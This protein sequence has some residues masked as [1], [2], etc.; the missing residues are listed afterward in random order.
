M[1]NTN[2]GAAAG[3]DVALST[4]HIDHKWREDFVLEQRLADRTGA[5]IG[6]ALATVDTHCAE[7]GESAAEAFGDPAAYSR[8]LVGDRAGEPVRIS[9]RTIGGIGCGL[10]G[11]LVVPRAFAAWVEG[12]TFSASAGDLVAWVIVAALAAI[13][14]V[15]PTPVLAWLVRRR[16]TAFATPFVVLILLLIPQLLLRD[17]VLEATWVAPLV[18]GVV[19]LTL[20][21]VLTWPDLS[22]TDPVVDPRTV[23]AGS[24]GRTAGWVTALMFPVLT[25]VLIGVDAIL[26]LLT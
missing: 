22:V 4:P 8:S 25:L 26:R 24:S 2:S 19:L 1:T 5:Q 21:V 11:L 3:N 13:V 6:D 15:W 16:S 12:A 20:S 7:S 14:F 9:S 23:G 10:L 18:I 17:T